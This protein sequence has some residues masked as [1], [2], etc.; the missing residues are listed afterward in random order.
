MTMGFELERVLYETEDFLRRNLGS[1]SRREAKKRKLRRKFEEWMRRVR[2]AA[3]IFAGLLV[4]LIAFSL[5]I[6]PIGF[7]TWLVAL[8]TAAF[9]AFLSLFCGFG[10][11]A[12]PS[13]PAHPPAVPLPALAP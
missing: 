13:D 9:I 7:F 3:V 10:K 1:R 11:R 12:V 5:F 4:A 6:D 2:R 8:P